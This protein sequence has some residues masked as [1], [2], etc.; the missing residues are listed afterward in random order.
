MAYTT[1]YDDDELFCFVFFASSE[2]PF[3]PIYIYLLSMF[4]DVNIYILYFLFL[5]YK[6]YEIKILQKISIRILLIKNKFL[7]LCQ[8]NTINYF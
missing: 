3:Y 6:I 4:Y 8:K 2:I 5:L 1:F 7:F